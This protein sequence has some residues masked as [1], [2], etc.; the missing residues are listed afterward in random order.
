MGE[1]HHGEGC[2]VPVIDHATAIVRSDILAK[3]HELANMIMTSREVEFY[4]Q[5]EQ[6]I[7]ENERVQGLISLIKKRQKEAVAF[8]SFQNQKMVEKIEG[9][10]VTLQD[11]LDSIPIVVEFQQAQQD[12]ND[13]LQLIMRVIT[14]SVSEKLNVENG[15]DSPVNRSTCSD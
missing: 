4:R 5:A 10:I 3:T 8:E 1:H 11:E 6:K 7:N 9:E 13:L 12:I 2:A 15:A 14:D